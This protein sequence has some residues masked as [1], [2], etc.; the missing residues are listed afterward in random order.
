M[1]DLSISDNGHTHL[2]CAVVT[3]AEGDA[4]G[5]VREQRRNDCNGTTS[6]S[7]AENIYNATSHRKKS[8]ISG[9][10]FFVIVDILSFQL[11]LKFE[12]GQ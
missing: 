5:W 7:R 12:H 9:S 2:S 8:P 3:P 1:C 4:I 11:Q 10:H 6:W